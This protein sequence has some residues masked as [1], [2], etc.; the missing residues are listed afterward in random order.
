MEAS[1]CVRPWALEMSWRLVGTVTT[2]G[3]TNSHGVTQNLIA[4]LHLSL[5]QPA[6]LTLGHCKNVCWALGNGAAPCLCQH[7]ETH[8][9]KVPPFQ[10]APGAHR[11]VRAQP[12]Q[13][14]AAFPCV[15]PHDL[16]LAFSQCCHSPHAMQIAR[17]YGKD[18]HMRNITELPTHLTAGR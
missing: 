17:G 11:A 12:C 4:V 6:S 14:H 8:R 15:Q 3:S 9:H 7:Q 13:G 18:K 5:S 16:L 10:A 1:C 2:C